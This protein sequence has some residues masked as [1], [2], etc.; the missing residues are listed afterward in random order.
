M[1]QYSSVEIY[2]ACKPQPTLEFHNPNMHEWYGQEVRNVC[3]ILS[4]RFHLMLLL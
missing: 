3:I 1:F 4:C 2:N